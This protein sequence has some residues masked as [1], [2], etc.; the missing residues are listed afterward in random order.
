MAGVELMPLQYTLVC[1]SQTKVGVNWSMGKWHK[2]EFNPAAARIFVVGGA[3]NYCLETVQHPPAKGLIELNRR[4]VC[5]ESGRVGEKMDGLH[6]NTCDEV[7]TK[8]HGAWGVTL[9]CRNPTLVMNARPD[10][11]YHL[12]LIH[13]DVEDAASAE[14]DS[15]FVEVGKCS[16]VK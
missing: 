2:V 16:V 9:E 12:S 11:W 14:K 13:N 1:Q 7:Y 4:P 8:P 10:G 15:M 6:H 3:D 5:V